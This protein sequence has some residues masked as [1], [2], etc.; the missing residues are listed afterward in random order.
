LSG[1]SWEPAGWGCEPGGSTQRPRRQVQ[2]VVPDSRS[3]R[4]CGLESGQGSNGLQV[5]SQ[6]EQQREKNGQEVAASPGSEEAEDFQMVESGKL[7]GV[8]LDYINLNTRKIALQLH[9]AFRNRLGPVPSGKCS[10][11]YPEACREW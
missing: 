6:E 8:Y 5:S 3:F 1:R 9:S 11:S 10:Q 2:A 4:I 7:R